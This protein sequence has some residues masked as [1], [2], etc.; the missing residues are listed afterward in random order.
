MGTGGQANAD[1]GWRGGGHLFVCY[2]CLGIMGI[3]A[4]YSALCKKC[5]KIDF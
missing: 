2:A 1:E 3:R 5:K 4:I